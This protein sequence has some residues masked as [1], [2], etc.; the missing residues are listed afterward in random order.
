M[1]IFV[2]VVVVDNLL[3][4]VILVKKRINSSVG[5]VINKVLLNLFLCIS[6]FCGLIVDFL[7]D[8]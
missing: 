8:F 4:V 3:L 1:L 2:M 5:I 7:V 6:V